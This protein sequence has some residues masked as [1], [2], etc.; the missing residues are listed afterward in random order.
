MQANNKKLLFI[1]IPSLLVIVAG[2]LLAYFFLWRTSNNPTDIYGQGMK[3]MGVGLGRV[4][5]SDFIES[6]SASEFEGSLIVTVP[7]SLLDGQQLLDTGSCQLIGESSQLQISGSDTST[8]SSQLEADW[9]VDGQNQFGIDF[10]AI[11]AEGKV[12]PDIYFKL[13]QTDCTRT[14]QQLLGNAPGSNA[15]LDSL[16]GTWWFFDEQTLIDAGLL[17]QSELDDLINA[18][19][20]GLLTD[21]TEEDYQN[22]LDAWVETAREYIFTDRT[23]RMVFQLDVSS[24][25]DARF[26]GQATEKYDVLLNKRNMNDFLKQLRADY[27]A[28]SFHQKL[29][30]KAENDGNFYYDASEEE[31]SD[32]EISEFV[33]DI[34][35]GIKI[36]AWLDRQ[37]GVLRNLRFSDSGGS[38]DTY[39]DVGFVLGDDTVSFDIDFVSGRDGR[40]E[41]SLRHNF[42]IN[43][44]SNEVSL[45]FVYTFDIAPLGSG[46]VLDFDFKVVAKENVPPLQPPADYKPLSELLEDLGVSPQSRQS[47]LEPAEDLYNETIAT[48][49]QAALE[50]Y[51]SN[52]NGR[53]PGSSTEFNNFVDSVV[54][55]SELEYLYSTEAPVVGVTDHP[56]YDEIHIY[57]GFACGGIYPVAEV[58]KYQE[59]YL[60]SATSRGYAIVY[61]SSPDAWPTC[62]DNS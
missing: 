6:I 23:E 27:F 3:G 2:L 49:L 28:S 45:K 35:E 14:I 32:E 18:W 40:E 37:N 20:S 13:D 43:S 36:E 29:L 26:K 25:E 53:L 24:A 11:A 33:D 34:A 5:D 50:T 17:S 62:R 41:L 44:Q 54:G 61:L 30:Q 52:N 15:N 56:G 55:S 19:Q 51:A 57:A 1:L 42:K 46:L 31:I 12:L 7:P 58:T 10:K 16:F 38:G 59:G 39:V 60:T 48:S 4:A 47:S 22:L 21:V 8:G 9:L